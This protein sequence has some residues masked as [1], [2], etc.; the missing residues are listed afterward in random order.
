MDQPVSLDT[1]LISIYS[2]HLYIQSTAVEKGQLDEV[3]IV[4]ILCWEV[5][6]WQVS[7]C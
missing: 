4:I 6:P 1:F 5:V 7:N 2:P 3:N